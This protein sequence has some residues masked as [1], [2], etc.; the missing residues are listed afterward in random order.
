MGQFAPLP[1]RRLSEDQ[2]DSVRRSICDLAEGLTDDQV[3]C[4][5]DGLHDMLRT[6]RELRHRQHERFER[7][8]CEG[9]VA[10]PF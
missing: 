5:A 3:L 6:R 8:Q 2:V 4:L 10:F 9:G 7:R 1:P